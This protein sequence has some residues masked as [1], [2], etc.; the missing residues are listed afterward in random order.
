RREYPRPRLFDEP[1]ARQDRHGVPEAGA[2]PD[3]HL[4]ERRLRHPPP[5]ETVEGGHGRPRGTGAAP[6]RA[7]GRG[8]G[9]AQAE[10]TRPLR[11]PAA[12]PV[13]CPRDRAEAGS[14]AAGRAHL[15]A[16]PDRHQPH[17]GTGGRTEEPVHH[18]HR[19]PQHAAGRTRLRPHR[20]HVSGRADRVR[21]DRED[22]HQAG[23]EADR[24]LHNRAL[25]LITQDHTMNTGTDH[26]IKSYDSELTRPPGAWSTTTTRSTGWSRTSA[27]TWCACWPCARRWRAICATCLPRCASRPISSASATTPPTWPSARSRCRWW[28][29]C[30]RSPVLNIW[31]R[32]PRPGCATSSPPTRIATPNV[33]TRYGR[34]T[35]CWTR[36]TPATSG[37]C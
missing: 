18:R 21:P 15:R 24:G 34:T 2:V 16:R 25:R 26:I 14:I 7:V 20:L 4:R 29:R 31:P 3:D 33:P 23:Q 22:L 36:P 19:H 27:T 10:R 9:Q 11:R 37:N 13:H 32:W 8:E 5:R 30:D 17:R 6:R 28:H 35:P 1:P 12:A